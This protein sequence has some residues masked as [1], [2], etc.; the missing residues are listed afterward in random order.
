[1]KKKFP[2]KRLRNSPSGRGLALSALGALVALTAC[3]DLELDSEFQSEVTVNTCEDGCG[4]GTCAED[5]C[6]ASTSS[7]G[8]LLFEVSPP[9]GTPSVGGIG[10][11]QIVTKEDIEAREYN[12]ALGHLARVMA[13]VSP[14]EL[15][16]ESCVL[17]EEN[18]EVPSL[19]DSFPIRFTLIPRARQLGLPNPS[20]SAETDAAGGAPEL[21][22][23]PG[24]YDIYVE[25]LAASSNCIVPPYLALNAEVGA[26]EGEID[27]R[28]P[29]PEALS[30]TVR[31]P[32]SAGD[33]SDWVA[34]IVERDS[35]RPLSNARKL[36]EAQVVQ[37]ALEYSVKLA[38]SQVGGQEGESSELI[39][40]RPPEAAVA[41]TIYVERSVVELFQGGAGLIDQLTRLADPV[42]YSLRIAALGVPDP[43]PS[44]VR[45][46]AL[47]LDSTEPGTVAQFSRNVETNDQGLAQ[48][49]LLP[50]DYRVSVQPHSDEFAV[51]EAT[52]RVGSDGETQVGK[53]VEVAPRASLSGRV[54]AFNNGALKGAIVKAK[55]AR[56]EQFPSIL[57]QAQ[58]EVNSPALSTE[59]VTEGS[60]EFSIVADPGVFHVQVQPPPSS[61][62]PWAIVSQQEIE[63]EAV[64]LGDVSVSLPLVVRGT[65]SS[66]TDDKAIKNALIRVHA[67][68]KEGELVDDPEEADALVQV[69][70]TRTLD[71]GNFRLLLPSS[72]K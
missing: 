58:G 47:Q 43:V 15:D 30:L 28:L 64:S 46:I 71:A 32:Q 53:L 27:L 65:L 6:Q 61:H 57:E 50:G 14:P 37:D 2:R 3:A 51:T 66:G 22:V 12:L 60:G 24:A 44:S 49:E 67:F 45:F 1:M 29:A 33:L 52:V 70:E 11:T 72:F 4:S 39:R 48:A 21:T 7:L 68:M 35:G 42:D 18:E 17:V 56:I 16:I 63:S 20:Y 9:V 31:F 69:A 23:P 8:T 5:I 41:P 13:P 26:G 38:F 19:E 40:L 36:G 34:D 54:K 25:P 55:F 62:F 10:F 59:T